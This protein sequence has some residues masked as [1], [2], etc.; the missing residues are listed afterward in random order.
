MR[1]IAALFVTMMVLPTA[2]YAQA[3]EIQVYDGG[4][5]EPGVFN[6]TLH[7]NW[8]AKGIS[9][10]A[11]PGAV[12]ADKSFNGVPEWAYGVN[13]WFELGLY[14]PLYS[15]DDRTGWGVNGFKLRTLFAVPNADDRT[16]FYGANI[17]YSFNNKRWDTKRFTSEVRPIVG[18]HLSQWD[19]IFNPIIDTAYDGLKNLEFV[20]GSRLAYNVSPKLAFAVEE[21]AGFGP[22]RDFV[23]RSEQSHQVFGVF[24]YNGKAFSVEGGI[25]FGLTDA[26]DDLTFKVILS[27]DFNQPRK[28][29]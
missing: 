29:P 8:I 12:A 3:D 18:W 10:P 1:W 15:R 17:E 22:L 13:R 20:P 14:L 23:P 9:T 26:S 24:D 4:L 7:N 25:G 28:K 6:L 16:F 21:Y 5:A 27:H 19:L 2:A 11:F